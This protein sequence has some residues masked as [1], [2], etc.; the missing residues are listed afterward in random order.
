MKL[1]ERKEKE[2]KKKKRKEKK[3]KEK[4]RTENKEDKGWMMLECE[5]IGWK[6]GES[7]TAVP[8]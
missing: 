4:K 8:E 3:K 1:K 2:K 7:P 5:G 6:L